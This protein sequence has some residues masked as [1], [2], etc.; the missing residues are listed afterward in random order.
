MKAVEMYYTPAE[1]GFLLRLNPKTVKAKAKAREFGPDVVDLGTSA[2]PDYR[3][4]ASGIN[5]Y[6]TARRLFFRPGIAARSTGELRR[7]AATH[8]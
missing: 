1:A 2:R 6:L 8:D 5:E 3:I 7:L 4:P